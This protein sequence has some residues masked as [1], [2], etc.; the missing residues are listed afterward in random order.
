MQRK[1]RHPPGS[2]LL[3]QLDTPLPKPESTPQNDPFNL[4]GRPHL[5]SLLEQAEDSADIAEALKSEFVQKANALRQNGASGDRLTEHRAA[6]EEWIARLRQ[7]F[8][9]W[10]AKGSPAWPPVKRLEYLVYW[11]DQ[12]EGK[13]ALM[14]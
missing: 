7:V 2:P 8:A 14:R 13:M 12:P 11:V 6:V 3:P 5:K 1:L 10:K 9:A 4:G